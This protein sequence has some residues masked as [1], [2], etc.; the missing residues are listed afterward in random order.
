MTPTRTRPVL[1][2]QQV[3]VNRLITVAMLGLLA[4][5]LRNVPVVDGWIAALTGTQ[6]FRSH[7]VFQRFEQLKTARPSP[8]GRHL[9]AGGNTAHGSSFTGTVILWN[10][11]T[12]QREWTTVLP[13]EDF[14]TTEHLTWSPDGQTI[15][16]ASGN[17]LH[18]LSVQTGKEV[19][20]IT[21]VTSYVCGLR[22]LPQGLL[23]TEGTHG[24]PAFL[25]LRAWPDL[26]LVWRVP[27]H[28]VGSNH[29]G[30]VD[31]RGRLMAFSSEDTPESMGVALVDL[32]RRTVLPYRLERTDGVGTA[33]ANAAMSFAVNPD[34]V[35]VAAGYP[36]GTI[37]VWNARTRKELW[38]TRPYRDLVFQLSWNPDGTT[39]ASSAFGRCSWWRSKCVALSKKTGAG[40]Q[41][42]IIH[43]GDLVTDLYW[44]DA[45][46]L[47]MTTGTH[48]FTA[49]VSK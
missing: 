16:A 44:N 22:T 39:L 27:M 31:P 34:G 8:D 10:T 32:T 28:C 41:S 24:G 37:I 12:G 14:S 26:Q 5:Q 49:H 45:G 6:S 13:T 9:A 36:D 29:G 30:D 23:M 4:T 40:V 2:K 15:L 38:R 3:L 1:S 7:T 18:I 47:L 19:R 17:I 48:A 42:Q 33:Y 21:G 11:V 25:T 43:S 20:A 35:E 46:T